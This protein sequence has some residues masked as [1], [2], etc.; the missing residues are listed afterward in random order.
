MMNTL[1][2]C[3]WK[4]P[5]NKPPILNHYWM[6]YCELYICFMSKWWIYN[7]C[8]SNHTYHHKNVYQCNKQIG[9]GEHFDGRTD[10][11]TNGR[12]TQ[13]GENQIQHEDE[14]FVGFRN[15]TCRVWTKIDNKIVEKDNDPAL[16]YL[17]YLVYSSYREHFKWYGFAKEADSKFILNQI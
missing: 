15:E 5:Q 8:S 9:N 7:L 1:T 12:G 13:S 3:T 6:F 2:I 17:V 11:E 10:E 16:V 4:N 14:E